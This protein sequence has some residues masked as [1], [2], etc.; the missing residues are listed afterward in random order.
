MN[1]KSYFGQTTQ[2][3]ARRKGEHIYR[4][5]S[6]ERDHKIYLA[7][8]KYGLDAFD[9]QVFCSC[10]D[11]DGLNTTETAMI[12]EY[13]TYQN[14]YNMTIGGDFVSDETREKLRKIFTGRKI[15]W[16]QKISKSKKGV[17]TGR[18]MSGRKSP[19]HKTFIITDPNGVE[20]VAMGL[21]QFCRRWKRDKLFHNNLLQVAMGRW[22]HYKGYKCRY[23][24]RATT[25]PQGST[26]KWLETGEALKRAVI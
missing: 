6:K 25:I 1:G 13:D 21:R 16:G 2:G 18:N 17:P 19:R 11:Q 10:F 15:T 22:N 12:K 3:I 23:H 20:H 24:E 8:K 4:F 5:K 14:G 9:F 7:F 26:A